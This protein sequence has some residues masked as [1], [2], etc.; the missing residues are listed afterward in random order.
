[1]P[2]GLASLADRLTGGS[3]VDMFDLGWW[4]VFNL[5]HVLIVTGVGLVLLLAPRRK[6]ATPADGD[7]A[8]TTEG[9]A[10]APD[11]PSGPDPVGGVNGERRA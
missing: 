9:T 7:S 4:P 11:A 2:R 5:A 8:A 6:P 10:P 3:V 1:M